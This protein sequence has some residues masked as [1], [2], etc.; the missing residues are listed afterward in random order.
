[1]KENVPWTATCNDHCNEADQ[2]VMA[3]AAA[4]KK[5]YSSNQK[6]GKAY[7]RIETQVIHKNFRD[8]NITRL[9]HN[10]MNT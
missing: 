4:V 5:I 6:T 1:M 2:H 3:L 8:K 7:G 9:V 10:V